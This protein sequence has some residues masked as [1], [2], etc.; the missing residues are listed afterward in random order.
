MTIGMPNIKAIDAAIGAGLVDAI[1]KAINVPNELIELSVQSVTA[2]IGAIGE[3][4]ICIKYQDLFWL[5][6]KWVKTSPRTGT[7]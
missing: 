4:I 2:E 5:S 7:F 1:Y 6:G 3:V